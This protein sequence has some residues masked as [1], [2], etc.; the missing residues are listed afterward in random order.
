MHSVIIIE[1]NY[2]DRDCDVFLLEDC[3]AVNNKCCPVIGAEPY[4]HNGLVV[5]K[6]CLLTLQ[7]LSC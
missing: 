5:Q 2:S 6:K 1:D 4:S 7:A 3:K